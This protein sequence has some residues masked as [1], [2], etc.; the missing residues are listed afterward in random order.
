[1]YF[2]H[3]M[4]RLSLTDAAFA[5]V[6]APCVITIQNIFAHRVASTSLC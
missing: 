5:G 3:S 4:A 2:F 6:N 1:M